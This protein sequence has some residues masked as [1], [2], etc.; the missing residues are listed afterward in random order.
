MPTMK[1]ISSPGLAI[2][3]AIVWV[4]PS[5]AARLCREAETASPVEAPMVVVKA[6]TPPAGIKAVDGAADNTYLEVPLGVGKPPK[7]TAGKATFSLTIPADGAYVLW[8]RVYWEGEC[9]NS[10]QAQIDEHPVFVIGEDAT[11]H[12]WHWVK[13]PVSKLTKPQDLTQGKHTLVLTHRED[14]VRVDQLIL[15]SDKRF[16]PVGIEPVGVRP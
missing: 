8:L 15:S 2:C 5:V 16:V 6:N 7:V 9:S 11:Y 3:L 12:A 4:S 14:G 13:Y 10:F 1:R